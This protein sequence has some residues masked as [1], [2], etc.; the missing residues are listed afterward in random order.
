MRHSLAAGISPQ[1]NPDNERQLPA[2]ALSTLAH[3]TRHW[4]YTYDTALPAAFQVIEIVTED[5]SPVGTAIGEFLATESSDFRRRQ[6]L[7]T[8]A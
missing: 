7:A 6:D 4:R 5:R 3:N 1:H 2:W 8:F